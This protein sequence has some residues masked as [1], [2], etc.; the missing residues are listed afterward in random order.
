MPID[1]FSVVWPNSQD[2]DNWD[3]RCDT[4]GQE[5]PVIIGQMNAAITAMNLN[6][7]NATSATSHS[8]AI[9]SKAFTTQSGKSFV[10]GMWVVIAD[11]ADSTKQMVAIVTSY[12]GTS[13]IGNVQ[14]HSGF[15]GSLANWVISQCAPYNTNA[16]GD[17]IVFRTSNN[18]GAVDTYIR[19]YTTL[20]TNTGVSY[21]YS[22]TANNGTVITINATGLYVL[23]L[24]EHSSGYRV[25]FS[26]NSNQLTSAINTITQSHIL[27]TGGADSVAV[28]AKLTAGDLI[29]AHASSVAASADT[30]NRAMLSIKRIL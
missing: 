27:I 10:A 23:A 30:N 12:S 22:T 20:V 11:S 9:G 19:A 14:W 3:A 5:F 24:T 4:I 18:W 16:I 8:A 2:P 6:S 21:S 7:V 15:A 28:A 1:Q 17:E 25:G 13:L 26:K 29:R